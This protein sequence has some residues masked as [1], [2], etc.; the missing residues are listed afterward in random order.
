[1]SPPAKNEYEYYAQILD[2]F[3]KLDNP[4]A[5]LDVFVSREIIK[6]LRELKYPIVDSANEK[7][8]MSNIVKNSI[9]L[10]LA[11]YKQDQADSFRNFKDFEEPQQEM[12][13]KELLTLISV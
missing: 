7:E 2:R 13:Q 8:K 4:E 11:L 10:L 1:M 5:S 3:R 6:V 12:I 9:I